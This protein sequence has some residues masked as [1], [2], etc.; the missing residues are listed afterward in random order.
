[1]RKACILYMDYKTAEKYTG[2]CVLRFHEEI[3]EEGGS[4]K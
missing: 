2:L 3:K 1:M 4:T